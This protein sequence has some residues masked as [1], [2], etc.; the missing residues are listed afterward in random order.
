VSVLRAS[1]LL[2][3]ALDRIGESV[4]NHGP[5]ET[6]IADLVRIEVEN[7]EAED[8]GIPLPNSA[9][10][11]SWATAFL[12]AP[13]S[14]VSIDAGADATGMS[15]RSFTRHFE[16]E[17]GRTFSEWK[18]LVMVQHAI[19]RLA[20]GDSVSAVAFDLGYENASAF[21]AMFKAMRGVS[22]R[23]FIGSSVVAPAEC[24]PVL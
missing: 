3:T 6:V 19:E 16:A 9:R 8:F 5:L 11:R 18:R 14:K 1:L 7:T 2:I 15:R 20:N 17:T 10:L 12:N 24:E 23:Q 21:I 22:P 13:S 4:G